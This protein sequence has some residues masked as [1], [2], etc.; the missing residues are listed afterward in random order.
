MAVTFVEHLVAWKDPLATLR[1]AVSITR[2][3]GA[4]IVFNRMA[5]KP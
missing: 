1:F 3:M 4:L 5:E 2:V